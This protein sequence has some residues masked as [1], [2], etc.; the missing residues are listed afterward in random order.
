MATIR[1]IMFLNKLDILHLALLIVQFALIYLGLRKAKTLGASD[2]G[3]TYMVQP[4]AY[5]QVT[6]QQA[7]PPY[8]LPIY[9]VGAD[10]VINPD[11]I[12]TFQ[13]YSTQLAQIIGAVV[14]GTDI[15]TTSVTPN[16]VNP[17]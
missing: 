8:P 15:T 10:A 1:L 9:Q 5:P 7:P 17:N 12:V 4:L 13:V 2:Y 11:G 3:R 6:Y 14:E 16:V